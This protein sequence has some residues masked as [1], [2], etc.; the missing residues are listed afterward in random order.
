M[1]DQGSGKCGMPRE[2]LVGAPYRRN[3]RIALVLA[4]VFLFEAAWLASG[5]NWILT[6]LVAYLSV[7]FACYSY[8]QHLLHRR[9]VTEAVWMAFFLAGEKTAPLEPCCLRFGE[10][11]SL[12]DERR[13]TRP[14]SLLRQ[15]PRIPQKEEAR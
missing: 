2:R 12:H 5:S 8:R 3:S 4:L 10:T 11:R 14:G 7:F 15:K 1:Q 13:C 6:V 9:L